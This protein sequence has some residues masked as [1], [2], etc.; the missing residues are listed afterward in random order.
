MSTMSCSELASEPE[1]DAAYAACW[2]EARTV[3]A[4]TPEVREFCAGYVKVLFECGAW[5][6]TA[7]CEDDWGMVSRQ[8]LDRIVACES[9]ACDEL[10][11][12]IDAALGAP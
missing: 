5:Y 12:C 2:D 11:A 1:W 3:V 9:R 10:E 8:V 6:S 4:T 7:E